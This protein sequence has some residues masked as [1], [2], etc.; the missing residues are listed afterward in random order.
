MDKITEIALGRVPT[1]KYALIDSIMQTLWYADPQTVGMVAAHL[2]MDWQG[3]V[4]QRENARKVLTARADMGKLEKCRG[5]FKLTGLK[6]NHEEH[7]RAITEQ[8]ARIMMTP[9]QPIIKR[10][11]ALPNNLRADIAFV[12][13]DFENRKQLAAVMEICLNE[14]PSYLEMKRNEHR[15]TKKQTA[16]YLSELFG[17]SI[18]H[19]AILVS[20]KDVSWAGSLEE[21]I[22]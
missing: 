12:L 21:I 3:E 5:Y 15:R 16:A 1:D 22:K 17:Y 19:Y 9:Y 11:V 18:N 2:G 7:S 4:S 13:R 20:G 10:E 8:I 6:G 14:R